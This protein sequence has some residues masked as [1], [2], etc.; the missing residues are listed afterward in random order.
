MP[1]KPQPVQMKSR[2]LRAEEKDFLAFVFPITTIHEKRTLAFRE[3]LNVAKG[4]RQSIRE[5]DDFEIHTPHDS[6]QLARMFAQLLSKDEHCFSEDYQKLTEF[7]L[8][9]AQ[10]LQFTNH[11]GKGVALLD[12]M[13]LCTWINAYMSLETPSL[14][15]EEQFALGLASAYV[16]TYINRYA[17]E[18]DTLPNGDGNLKRD[19]PSGTLLGQ[20]GFNIT[21]QDAVEKLW[22]SYFPRPNGREFSSPSYMRR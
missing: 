1:H 21:M 6:Q 5:H 13:E 20:R 16:L 11:N 3:M 22:N 7:T 10:E 8:A 12:P 9:K 4:I 2:L 18:R 17:I 15:R 14:S 19:I